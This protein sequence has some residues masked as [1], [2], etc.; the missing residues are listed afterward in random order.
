VVLHWNT[1]GGHERLADAMIAL[2]DRSPE[3]VRDLTTSHEY[4]FHDL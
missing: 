1:P 3:A 4:M 2:Q